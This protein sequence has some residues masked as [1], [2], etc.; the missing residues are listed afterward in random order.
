[1]ESF[2]SFTDVC[3]EVFV[4]Q[5]LFHGGKKLFDSYPGDAVRTQSG[6]GFK[7]WPGYR[8]KVG[9]VL[10]LEVLLVE[11]HDLLKVILNGSVGGPERMAPIPSCLRLSVLQ[12]ALEV[13]SCRLL[14]SASLFILRLGCCLGRRMGRCLGRCVGRCFGCASL[15]SL[16]GTT[17]FFLFRSSTDSSFGCRCL[18]VTLTLCG[19]SLS[20]FPIEPF[21]LPPG[22]QKHG[23][24]LRIGFHFEGVDGRCGRWPSSSRIKFSGRSG[25]RL[26][27]RWLSGRAEWWRVQGCCRFLG[28]LSFS[29]HP[30][31]V[32]LESSL[33]TLILYFFY[34]HGKRRGVV[35]FSALA[36]RGTVGL[37]V[38]F[39]GATLF[40]RY[41]CNSN[42]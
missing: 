40:L 17:T 39:R 8:V 11:L 21:E 7:N 20:L 35:E 15:L 14:C 28:P 29:R 41:P 18:S 32:A 26:R 36:S 9:L 31:L 16:G 4:T 19:I 5:V 25:I 30:C 33:M 34:A 37:W 2:L 12:L 1:M 23:E 38:D 42:V 27:R 22:L 24:A 6:R 3:L 10:R 13:L